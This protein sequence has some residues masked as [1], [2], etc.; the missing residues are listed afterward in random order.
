MQSDSHRPN[1]IDFLKLQGR[2]PRFE[3]EQLKRPVRRSLNLSR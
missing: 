1:L 3:L 2:V